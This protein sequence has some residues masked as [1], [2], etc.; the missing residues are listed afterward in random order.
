MKRISL[1]VDGMHC[2]SCAAAIERRLRHEP[3][4]DSAEVNV[5]TQMAAIAYDEAQ[6]TPRQL[7]AAVRD[8]GYEVDEQDTS[9]PVDGM[10]CAACVGRVEKA[11]SRVPGVVD[12]VVNLAT[13]MATITYLAGM[14]T[15]ADLHAAVRDAGYG[16]PVL[17]QPA[18]VGIAPEV[19][20]YQRQRL[21]KELTLLRR[22]L[23]IAGT[24]GGIVVLVSMGVTQAVSLLHL[25]LS[26]PLALTLAWVLLVLATVVQ[27]GPGWRFL[28]SAWRGA[29]HGQADMN[30]L[31]ALG[32]LSAWA[33]SVLVVW[34]PSLVLAPMMHGMPPAASILHFLYFDTSVVIIGLILLGR[35]FEAR[36]RSGTSAA[37]HK[38]MGL[39]PR[40]ARVIRGGETVD[41]PIAEVVAGDIILV[42]PGEKIPVDGEVIEGRSTIDESM[43]TG[44]SL[45][46]EKG[47]GGTVFGAT[48]NRTGSFTFRADRVG[49]ATVLA[50]IIRLVAEAQGRKAPVQRLADTVAGIFV[51]VVLLIAMVTLLAWVFI[52]P[53]AYLLPGQTRLVAA[54]LHFVAVLI[55]ACPCALGLATPTAIMVGTGRAAEMGILI[56]GGEVLERAHALTVIV[57]DKTGTLT[58]GQPKVTAVVA[59][60]GDDDALL[61]LAAAVEVGSE[62]PLGEALVHEARLRGLALPAVLEFAAVPGRGV[63]AEVD[64]QRVFVGN[65]A[66]LAERG[67][68]LTPITEEASALAEHGATP[69]YLAAKGRVLGVIGVADTVRPNAVMAVEWLRKIGLTP[70]MLTGDHTRV[71]EAIARQ[72]GIDRVLAEVLPPHKANEVKRLQNEGAIVAMVGDGINDAPALAQADLGIAVGSGTDVAL[73]ASD[74]TLVGDDLT[75]VVV[76]IDLSRRTLRT[77]KQNLF[78]AFIYNILGIPIAAGVLA[79]LGLA[80]S[81]MLAALAMAFSSVFVVSNSLRLRGYRPPGA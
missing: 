2:A 47:P 12:A 60:D 79:P 59:L 63:E 8:A 31:I 40:T 61:R 56:K 54:L 65:A 53:Q 71:A 11:L 81:P 45:P 62:H 80:L 25:D 77:I 43:L 21:E 7:I 4:V 48:L 55:I 1:P 20:D 15:P 51:P 44:E 14:T 57:F 50:Q 46:V 42:R 75:G 74:I 27:F 36:A 72:M 33:Y 73:E 67:I 78:W 6:T 58:H 68:D 35:Y 28:I 26:D 5:A 76:G 30:T 10:T 70:V 52:V 23:W 69:L 41:I 32:T 24:L 22:D 49:A 13:R 17:E 37:I 39:Q 64:E 18:T 16:V 66:F 3:G 38:L 19:V 34:R 9:F 29:W